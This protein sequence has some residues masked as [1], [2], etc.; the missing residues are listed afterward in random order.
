MK[1]ARDRI[2]GMPRWR[3]GAKLARHSPQLRIRLRVDHRLW[4]TVYAPVTMPVSMDVYKA[5]KHAV[6]SV[7]E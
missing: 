7:T 3:T 5:I 4:Y 1:P 2:Q 6:Q